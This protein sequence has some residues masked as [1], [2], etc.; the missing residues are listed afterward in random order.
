MTPG[1]IQNTLQGQA[2]TVQPGTEQ[3]QAPVQPG[4]NPAVTN[5]PGLP[6]TGLQQQMTSLNEQY[7]QNQQRQ[8]FGAEMRTTTGPD[9]FATE[10]PAGDRP[11]PE[12]QGPDNYA[13]SSLRD[14]AEKMATSYGLSFGRGTLVDASGNFMQT[15]D[16]LAGS[17]GDASATAASMNYIAQAIND[18]RIQM[19]RDKATAALSAGAGLLA[20]RG[21]GSLAELQSN[22]YQ[23]MAA[24]Y[25]DPNL[26][27]EQQ[28]FS[29][30]IEE[31]RFE[32]AAALR[33]LE[34]RDLGL[35]EGGGGSI[36]GKP[37]A[38]LDLL[39]GSPTTSTW[40]QMAYGT[41]GPESTTYSRSGTG[42]VVTS[43]PHAG[44]RPKY[45]YDPVKKVSTVS[46]VSGDGE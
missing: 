27:P 4:Q 14:L 46:W 33:E 16:Q 21:R 9:M 18:Q 34:N 31:A 32:E 37:Q 40:A 35:S 15:P 38:D 10:G 22:F 7:E 25:T 44:E 30:W 41:V 36:G 11:A 28:D 29:F 26:L 42:D 8:A 43:G 6:P 3:A 39:K 20:K 23:A 5:V 13:Q 12:N 19:Q 17:G 2:E 1:V 24:N 45:T